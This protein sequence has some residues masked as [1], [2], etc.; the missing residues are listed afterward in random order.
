M[1]TRTHFTVFLVAC[2]CCVRAGVFGQGYENL[3][4]IEKR[5]EKIAEKSGGDA[6]WEFL[7]DLQG[8]NRVF[9]DNA[10]NAKGMEDIKDRFVWLLKIVKQG[11]NLPPE[12]KRLSIL[13][14]GTQHAG[15]WVA[16]KAVQTAAEFILANKNK[17]DWPAEPRFQ[18]FTKFKDANIK[19]LTDDA[20]LFMIPVANPLG[21]QFSR[22]DVKKNELPPTEQGWRKNRQPTRLDKKD[23]YPPAPE[24]PAGANDTIIGVDMNRNFPTLNPAWATITIDPKTKRVTT[25]RDRAADTYCGRPEKGWN[26][27][28]LLPDPE[29]E[30]QCIMKLAQDRLFVGYIDLHSVFGL[31]GRPTNPDAVNKNLRPAGGLTD[32]KVFEQLTE[33]AAKLIIDPR[34]KKNYKAGKL[35]PTSGTTRDWLYEQTNKKCLA[36]LIEIGNLLKEDPLQGEYRPASPQPH[37]DAVLPGVLFLMLAAVDKSFPSEPK[38]G[39]EK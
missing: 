12:G 24:E 39:L 16:Y 8:R 33:Q 7:Q 21:Y 13:V 31:V 23:I 4:D 3:T 1:K 17:T 11:K 30:S 28:P 22:I 37:A 20:N 27:K 29:G 35:Y 15:E 10:P 26:A 14:T 6:S 18:Y 38:G 2:F 9:V 32:E 5:F 36:C 19:R 25:S 34:D